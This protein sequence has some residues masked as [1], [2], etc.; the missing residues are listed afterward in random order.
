MMI[1][2]GGERR[3][4][5]FCAYF[6]PNRGGGSGRSGLIVDISQRVRIQIGRKASNLRI[7]GHG[8]AE[9]AAVAAP[10]S[11]AMA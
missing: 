5:G 6:S 7:W 10:L 9:A 2:Q 1:G 11:P 8:A 4:A 3:I